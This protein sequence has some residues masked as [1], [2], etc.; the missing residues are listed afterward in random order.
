MNHCSSQF[1][2][3]RHH[4]SSG[5]TISPATER[6]EPASRG[7]TLIELLVTL[8]V[9]AILLAVAVPSFRT[10]VQN[11][12]LNSTANSLLSAFQQ[13]RSEAITRG[14]KVILC[15]TADSSTDSCGDSDPNDWSPGWLMYSV[16]TADGEVDYTGAADNVLISR[17][18]GAASDV[19]ITSDTDGNTW[20]TF[21]SDGTLAEPM[22]NGD[23][24]ALYAIC[25]DRGAD[26][27][28][29][30]VIPLIGRP[31]L[32]ELKDDLTK[33]PDCAPIN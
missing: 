24:V 26:A 23:E 28:K 6:R 14:A 18:S 25:D 12:Q 19:T 5:P 27:G 17:G 16:P 30:I 2:Q 7:F 4:R 9:A 15:R 1:G 33:A 21:G 20:L 31:Y 13:A 3:I 32:T 8:A 29:L 11:A 22:D 10:F